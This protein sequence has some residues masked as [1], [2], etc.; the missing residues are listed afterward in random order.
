MIFSTFDIHIMCLSSSEYDSEAESSDVDEFLN[1]VRKNGNSPTA[2]SWN[3]F[4]PKK[5]AVV[6]IIK[7]A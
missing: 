4:R 7:L 1:S 2:D 5:K 6:P 3:A